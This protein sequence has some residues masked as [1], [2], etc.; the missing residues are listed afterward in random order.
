MKRVPVKGENIC[1]PL[2]GMARICQGSML[3]SP[4]AIGKALGYCVGC[5]RC[6]VL[7]Q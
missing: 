3:H 2:V 6:V 1:S 4:I 5:E 7:W